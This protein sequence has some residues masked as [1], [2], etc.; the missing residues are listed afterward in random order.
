MSDKRNNTD[1]S[2]DEIDAACKVLEEA[3]CLRFP[4]C[5]ADRLVVRQMLI[6]ANSVRN[7]FQAVSQKP[8]GRQ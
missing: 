8:Q 5:A 3:N 6:S 7:A 2:A 1:V 4:I